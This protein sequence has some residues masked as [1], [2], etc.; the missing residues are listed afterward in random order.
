V[1]QE[2]ERLGESFAARGFDGLGNYGAYAALRIGEAL[3][4]GP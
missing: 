1:F 2:P 3:A 4:Q